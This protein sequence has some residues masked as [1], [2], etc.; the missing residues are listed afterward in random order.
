MGPLVLEAAGASELPL[1]YFPFLAGPSASRRS[2]H[3]D[4]VGGFRV[5]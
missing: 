3:A 4:G 5:K 1:F 2:G